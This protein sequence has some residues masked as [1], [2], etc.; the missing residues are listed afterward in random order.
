MSE[1]T[2]SVSLPTGPVCVALANSRLKARVCA[3][4]KVKGEVCEGGGE[5]QRPYNYWKRRAEL[6][7]KTITDTAE[8]GDRNRANRWIWRNRGE[9]SQSTGWEKVSG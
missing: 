8:G 3:H 6:R 2:I 7:G 9:M 5:G 4:G 1:Q